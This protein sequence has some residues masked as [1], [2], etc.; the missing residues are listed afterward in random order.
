MKNARI[1]TADDR[2]KLPIISPHRECRDENRYRGEIVFYLQ[3]MVVSV[4]LKKL[5]QS[6]QNALRPRLIWEGL[7][8]CAGRVL[9][10]SETNAFLKRYSS[11]TCRSKRTLNPRRRAGMRVY[12]RFEFSGFEKHAHW[13]ALFH[14]TDPCP[15]RL[16]STTNPT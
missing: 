6:P 10:D 8:F 14:T 16:G 2:H 15:Q 13:P 5:N 3:E 9:A 11:A 1:R 12:D 4:P 7:D